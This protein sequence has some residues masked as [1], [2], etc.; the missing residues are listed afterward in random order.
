MLNTAWQTLLAFTT[1]LA[2]HVLHGAIGDNHV[3]QIPRSLDHCRTSG[4]ALY[5]VLLEYEAISTYECNYVHKLAEVDDYK[6]G[7]TGEVQA[8]GYAYTIKGETLDDLL[9]AIADHVGCL[10]ANILVNPCG[11]DPSRID[12]QV[13]ENGEGFSASTQELSQWREG[14]LKLWLCDYSF[15]FETV[16]RESANFG[17]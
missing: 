7:C 4:I 13:I 2:E 3:P 9:G 1:F 16:T 10:K 15:Y 6:N 12:A 17:A 11:D 8:C 14:K 5:P